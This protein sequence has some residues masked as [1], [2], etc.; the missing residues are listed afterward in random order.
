MSVHKSS[1]ADIDLLLL[2]LSNEEQLKVPESMML[3]FVK[4]ESISKVV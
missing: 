1:A 2:L 3:D 4:Y